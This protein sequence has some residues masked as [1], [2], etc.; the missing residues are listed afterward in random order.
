MSNLVLTELAAV[1]SKDSHCLWRGRKTKR[2]RVFLNNDHPPF[3]FL[4]AACRIN[5]PLEE[6]ETSSSMVVHRLRM[7]LSRMR[8]WVMDSTEKA[9]ETAIT[10]ERS[11]HN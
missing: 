11:R 8:S 3:G 10:C 5:V 2:R 9:T 6:Q 7:Q 4:I 1:H